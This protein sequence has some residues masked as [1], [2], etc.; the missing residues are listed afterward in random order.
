MGDSK[1]KL[2]ENYFGRITRALAFIDAHLDS[3][4]SLERVAKI[5]YYSPFH[6]HRIFK[7]VI[8]EPLNAYIIRR[9]IEKVA[10]VLITQKGVSLAT[11]SMQYGFNSPSSFSR[12]FK[13]FYGLSPTEF[14]K[15]S[16][17]KFSKICIA[18]SKNGQE[19]VAFEKYLCNIDNHKKWI[20]MNAKIKIVE[21][22][23]QH[24]ACITHIGEQGLENTFE[25]LV[26]WAKPKGLLQNP[27]AKLA[28]VFHD[29]FKV[30]A[31]EKVRMSA[32]ILL[33]EPMGAEGEIG[34]AQIEKGKFIMG[35]FEIL[36]HA[37]EQAW[38]SLFVW[39]N[40]EGYRK[41]AQNPFEIYHND[42]REHPENKF[43]VDLYIPIEP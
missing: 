31:A 10:T 36:P 28:R 23:L 34:P 17:G 27:E 5:A 7:A 25:R 1:N 16:P 13:K 38:S 3:D 15:L 14:R 18:D 24:L 40:E 6:F 21:R 42:Y 8:G 39:M 9:R 22:P 12:A 26:K 35:R 32:C 2:E 41:A 4:L 20:K 29:S 43:I 30:T 37:F 19:K 33:D 11:L